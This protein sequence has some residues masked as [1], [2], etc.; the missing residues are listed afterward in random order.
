[1]NHCNNEEVVKIRQIKSLLSS[2]DQLNKS[3]LSVLFQTGG[4]TDVS[5][6]VIDHIFHQYDEDN[7][8][9][10]SSEQLLAIVKSVEE[11]SD[12]QEPNLIGPTL[13]IFSNSPPLYS[14]YDTIHSSSSP[15]VTINLFTAVDHNNIGFV[16]HDAL[17]MYLQDIGLNNPNEYLNT[18]LKTGDP[19]N[20]KVDTKIL[21]K[22]I[23][24]E[25]T[26]TVADNSL[27]KF[28]LAIILKEVNLQKW[29]NE[30]QTHEVEKLKNDLMISN[31]RLSSLALEMDENESKQDEIIR[32]DRKQ[33]DQKHQEQIRILKKSNEIELDIKSNLIEEQ[34]RQMTRLDETVRTLEAKHRNEVE[35][36]KQ[37]NDQLEKNLSSTKY[38][39]K[40]MKE[41]N[42][43]L[44]FEI[45]NPT[46]QDSYESMELS[47]LMVINKHLKDKNDELIMQLQSLTNTDDYVDF[48]ED[49]STDISQRLSIFYNQPQPESLKREC[50]I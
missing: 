39:L 38:D 12:Q 30:S 1:M 36:L 3:Q 13:Q 43:S 6:K 35:K 2:S 45:Q 42:T 27:S 31:E 11:S 28:S 34:Q 4:F 48:C 33:T 32:Q 37:T 26:D 47:E 41:L 22:L 16:N 23:I 15:P 44:T 8:G 14:E 25:F 20:D 17:L 7:T 46:Q 49:G 9:Y 19:R 24:E 50:K 40:H 29:L 21:S 5:E 10:V 18:Y